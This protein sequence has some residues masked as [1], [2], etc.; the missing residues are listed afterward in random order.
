MLRDDTQ[1]DAAESHCEVPACQVTGAVPVTCV[2]WGHRLCYPH[3]AGF[4]DWAE[5][6]GAIN[7]APT[8]TEWR[9]FLAWVA[10]L[11]PAETEAA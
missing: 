6:A 10:A 8:A 5:G 7:R 1:T 4:A 3:F 2:A 11:K 9:V